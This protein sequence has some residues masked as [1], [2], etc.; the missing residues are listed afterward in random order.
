M[1]LWGGHSLF[2]LRGWQGSYITFPSHVKSELG[3]K[4]YI[5]INSCFESSKNQRRGKQQVLIP[6]LPRE[7]SH[8]V[9]Q[10]WSKRPA[11]I[12][13]QCWDSCWMQAWLFVS[14]PQPAWKSGPG[15]WFCL[16]AFLV[17]PTQPFLGVWSGT[18]AV[19]HNPVSPITQ[20]WR[21]LLSCAVFPRAFVFPLGGPLSLPSVRLSSLMVILIISIWCCFQLPP[22]LQKAKKIESLF[23]CFWNTFS[24]KGQFQWTEKW[25]SNTFLEQIC[26]L[27][28][29]SN[30]VAMS[31]NYCISRTVF[32][33]LMWWSQDLNLRDVL[34]C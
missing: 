15:I 31:G 2:Y 28:T 23:L 1:V 25:L 12:P 26:M 27:S 33:G 32:Y 3:S 16:S 19:F 4:A 34:A 7:Q 17:L 22:Y 29:S 21:R 6:S 18:R 8:E 9:T 11:W 13:S 10:A 30:Q 20:E 5:L 14:L 24:V